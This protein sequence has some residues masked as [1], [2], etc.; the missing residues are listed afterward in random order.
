MGSASGF[1][2]V[3]SMPDHVILTKY[4]ALVYRAQQQRQA[5]VQAMDN[6]H[7]YT[8]MV[9]SMHKFCEISPKININFVA[10][11]LAA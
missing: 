11:R 10:G 8:F 3:E 1:A 5:K 9:S 4:N 2:P 7:V 6:I